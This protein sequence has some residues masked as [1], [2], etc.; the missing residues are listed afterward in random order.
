MMPG[1]ETVRNSDEERTLL[2]IALDCRKF[3]LCCVPASEDGEKRPD[4]DE[5]KTYQQ[6]LPT[7]ADLKSWFG[8]RRTGIGVVTGAISGNLEF[9]DFDSYDTFVE[10][11]ELAK[12][13]ELGD[14]AE[15]L[16]NGYHERTPCGAHLAYRCLEIDKNQK[17]AFTY[18]RDEHGNILTDE[19]KNPKKKTLIE[20]RGEGGFCIIAPSNGNVHPSGKPYTLV[21]GSLA[22]IPT[23]TPQE[24]QELFSLTR[25]L[26]EVV[27]TPQ[28]EHQAPH[29]G[30][31]NGER[32]GDRYNAR[33]TWA[34]VLAVSAAWMGERVRTRRRDLLAAPWEGSGRQCHNELPGFR[35]TLC[36][37]YLYAIHV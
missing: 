25:A 35:P 30:S 17:L 15:R 28:P 5:W 19:H 32:P 2:S 26:S 24:R 8:S 37:Q 10:F 16:L 34:D 36:L 9:L 6:R 4:L 27:D 12:M 11:L 20:T 22:T 29:P 31:N 23:I 3:Q 33:A 13:A 21:S 18:E 7:V 1:N 14:I